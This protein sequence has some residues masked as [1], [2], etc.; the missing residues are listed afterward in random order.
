MHVKYL[1]T[2]AE[3]NKIDCDRSYL[4]IYK[5]IHNWAR[6]K[7]TSKI[8]PILTPTKLIG[9]EVNLQRNPVITKTRL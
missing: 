2:F 3:N 1:I 4:H 6:D 8:E 7:Y 5:I 9:K